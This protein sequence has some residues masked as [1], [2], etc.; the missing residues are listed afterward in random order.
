MSRGSHPNSRKN[1][2]L[3]SGRPL[4]YG[5]PKRVHEMM[6]T[7]TAWNA[8]KEHA[9]SLGISVS[10][11]VERLGRQGAAAFAPAPE[12]DTETEG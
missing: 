2:R 8:L 12:P 7:D 9:Q 3:S 1:L 11:V 10:E 4:A 6:L 5:E